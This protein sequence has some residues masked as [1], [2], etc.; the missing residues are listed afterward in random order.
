MTQLFSTALVRRTVALASL[1]AVSACATGYGA[2]NPD[3]L[4]SNIYK[5]PPGSTLNQ[6]L[7]VFSNGDL[8]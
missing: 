8:L 3:D 6:D 5:S 2:N 4:Y 1:L 7:A